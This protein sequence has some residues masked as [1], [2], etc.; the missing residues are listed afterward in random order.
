MLK[1]GVLVG[2][3]GAQGVPVVEHLSSLN[4]YHLKV[5]TRSIKSP[6]AKALGDLPNVTLIE[7]QPWGYDEDSFNL[8][9][10]GA[11]FV[12]INT[13][14]FAIGEVS[15]V[16]WGIR[17]F[18]LAKAAGVKHFIY[19]SLDYVGQLT[20]FDPKFHVGHYDAKG[21]VVGMLNCSSTLT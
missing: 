6:Q 17:F 10:N 20:N 11:D 15:E 8:A 12:F 7:S 2:G 18:E 13:D 9:A 5:I 3:T 1:T 19:S 16:Y 14:G 21:R 4:E